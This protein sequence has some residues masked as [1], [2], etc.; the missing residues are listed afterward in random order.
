[1]AIYPLLDPIA[2]WHDALY[3]EFTLARCGVLRFHFGCAAQSRAEA[4]LRDLTVD[5]DDPPLSLS[6]RQLVRDLGSAISTEIN[7]RNRPTR[8]H[9]DPEN[10]AFIVSGTSTGLAGSRE[11]P[12][13]QVNARISYWRHDDR[14]GA[15]VEA[16]WFGPA[17]ALAA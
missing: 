13:G 5:D 9:N 8:S 17:E 3:A 6:L 7:G 1:M 4:L 11:H 10:T 14:L 15:T 16:L 12:D 2:W